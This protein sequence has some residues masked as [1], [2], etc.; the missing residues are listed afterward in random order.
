MFPPSFRNAQGANCRN[1]VEPHPTKTLLAGTSVVPRDPLD[2]G[3]DEVVAVRLA[4][5]V[6]EN[7][8]NRLGRGAERILVEIEPHRPFGETADGKVGKRLARTFL[9]EAEPRDRDSGSR[10]RQ[11]LKERTPRERRAL[12]IAG[13]RTIPVELHGHPPEVPTKYSGNLTDFSRRSMTRAAF[14]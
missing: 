9:G 5:T 3:V 8:G 12:G 6:L 4:K 13:P 14:P 1:S 7:R 11:G 10:G 2:Q